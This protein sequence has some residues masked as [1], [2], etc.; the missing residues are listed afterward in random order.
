LKLFKPAVFTLCLLPLAWLLW[1]A[2]VDNDLGANPVETITHFTGGWA[3]RLLLL[4]L[5]ATPL[6]RVTGWAWPLRLR[7]MLG[8]FA[9]FY[10]C[11]HFLT[12]L[13]L[14]HQADWGEISADILKRPYITVGFAAFVLLWP[15]A[16]TSTQAM[17]RRLGR[18]WVALHRSAYLIGLLGVLHYLWLVKADLLEPLLYGGVYVLLMAARWRAA[19]HSQGG[20]HNPHQARTW[21]F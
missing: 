6:R 17:M 14:D 19:R 16:L 13:A 21:M 18:R 11:L 20:R 7:R 10:A 12:W 9:F 8:L 4:T 15:L 3:L 1:R 2:T 5:A